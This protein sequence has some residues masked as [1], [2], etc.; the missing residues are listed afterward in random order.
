MYIF[1]LIINLIFSWVFYLFDGKIEALLFF[2]I[3]ILMFFYFSPM[4]FTK[5]DNKNSVLLKITPSKQSFKKIIPLFQKISYLVAFFFF[6]TSLYGISYY[7]W[8]QLFP[9]FTL[10]LNI[11]VSTI[12]F[13]TINKQKNIINLIYRS[14]FLVFSFIWIFLFVYKLINIQQ[15]DGIF[16]INSIL[17]LFWL[18]TT[19]IFD[20]SIETNKKK[21]YYIYFTIYSL[22]FII[23]YIQH[24]FRLKYLLFLPYLWFIMSI[25]YFDIITRIKQLFFYDDVSKYVGIFLNYFT[26]ICSWIL[27]FEYINFWHF[28]LILLGGIIFHY[29]IHFIYK[30]YISLILVLLSIILIYIKNFIVIW[31]FDFIHFLIFIYFLPFIYLWYSFFFKNKYQYDNYFL[32]FSWLIFS[33]FSIVTYFYLY[34]DTNI[35]HLSIILLLQSFLLFWGFAKLKIK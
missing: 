17:S 20:K 16:V 26:I 29:Y 5:K 11:F 33:I 10:L 22:I 31:K 9:Y 34:R 24:Y 27:L 12:F 1:F 8:W 25:F 32:I 28:V 18:V 2:F 15:I 13:S 35:L 14:N 19:L 7:F 23:F 6:Y 3:G 4:Y 30:N 21:T